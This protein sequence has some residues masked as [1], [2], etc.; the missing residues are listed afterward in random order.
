[1]LPKPEKKKKSKSDVQQLDLVDIADSAKNIK[2]K[3]TVLLFALL[4][5]FGLSLMFSIYQSLS[6]H[7]FT[8]SLPQLNLSSNISMLPTKTISL[9]SQL[10][11][12]LS[13]TPQLNF[14]LRTQNSDSTTYSYS[15][16]IDQ[17]FLD[18][19]YQTQ[20]SDLSLQ[21]ESTDSLLNKLLPQGVSLRQILSTKEEY[22]EAQYLIVV[23]KK[24]IF[25][26]LSGPQNHTN[27]VSEEKFAKLVEKI[28][29][30]ILNQSTQT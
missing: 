3:R 10:N 19:N 30:L 13:S 21:P 6:S 24:Q 9:D 1:M 11:N 4:C 23:P 16:N 29:F 14:Y 18:Q 26:I 5:T 8:F 22:L 7:Q 20:V 17:L 28:Y 15:Q 12:L 25:I 27:I 2:R